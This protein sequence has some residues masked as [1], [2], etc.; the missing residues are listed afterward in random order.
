MQL[1]HA[2]HV[3]TG[4]VFVTSFILYIKQINELLLLKIID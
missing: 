2:K 1:I 4:T 3:Y